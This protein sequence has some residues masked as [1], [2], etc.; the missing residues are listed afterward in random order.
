MEVRKNKT[1]EKGFKHQLVAEV[2]SGKISVSGAS[3]KYELSPITINNWRTKFSG[4]Q[5]SDGPT[6]PKK[7]GVFIGIRNRGN[8]FIGTARLK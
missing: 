7:G 2:E 4:G 8:S 6:R 5:L 1:D 3:K